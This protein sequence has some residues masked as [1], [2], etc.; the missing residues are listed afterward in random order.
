MRKRTILA[1]LLAF[2]ASVGITAMWSAEG[3]DGEEVSEVEEG[4]PLRSSL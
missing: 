2:I 1:V 4:Q 3:N